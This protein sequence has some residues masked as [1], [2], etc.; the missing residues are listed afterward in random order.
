M[1]RVL[2][3]WAGPVEGLAAAVGALR[4]EPGCVSAELYA[5]LA[6]G[7][8]QHALTLLFATEEQY[9]SAWDRML[10]GAHPTLLD[11]VRSAPVTEFY[12]RTPFALRAGTW[13]PEAT[14]EGARR[15]FWPAR[16]EV[17]IIITNAVEPNPALHAKIAAEILE[18]RR[19]QGC[20][21]YAWYE[22]AELPAHLLLLEVWADQVVYDR[23]WALRVAT[24]PFL[25]DNL[26]H[27]AE[28]VRGLVSREFYRRQQFRAHYDRWLPADAAAHATTI[29]YPAT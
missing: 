7:E 9:W 24:A 25:G 12:D 17:R 1:L 20:L 21:S 26:R 28:P 19:E 2:H 27:P 23:H 10:R 11:A 4:E 15:I 16:G 6:P 5:T 29:A 18:T 22:N 14:D 3:E 13:V 8:E